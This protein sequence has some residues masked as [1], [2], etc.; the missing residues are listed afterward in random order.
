ML[1]NAYSHRVALHWRKN[2]LNSY[3]KELKYAKFILA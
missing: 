3:M 2:K 1:L